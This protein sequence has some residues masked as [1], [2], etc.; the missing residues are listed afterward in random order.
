M[1]Q[2]EGL[3]TKI[4]NYVLRGF[5]EKKQEKKK[6]DRQPLFAQMPIFKKKEENTCDFQRQHIYTPTHNEHTSAEAKWNGIYHL[7]AG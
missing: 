4:Y 2:I 3:T 1:P 5:G 7:P 6:E